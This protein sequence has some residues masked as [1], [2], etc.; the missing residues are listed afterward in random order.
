[1]D[2]ACRNDVLV[3]QGVNAKGYGTIALS[4]MTDRR[5]SVESKAIYAYL[6]AYTGR[7]ATCYPSVSTICQDLG[8]S[9][10]RYYKFFAPLKDLGY[11]STAQGVREGSAY[12]HNVYTINQV[13]S[14]PRSPGF[15]PA[16]ESPESSAAAEP[17][18]N[19][20]GRFDH[21]R[22]EGGGPDCGKLG[23]VEKSAAKPQVN[24]AG[25]F[26]HVQIDHTNNK[27]Y[28]FKELKDLKTHKGLEDLDLPGED[29][30]VAPGPIA[31][32]APEAPPPAPVPPSGGACP[33]T[34]GGD[35][36]AQETDR[37]LTEAEYLDLAELCASAVNDNGN[38]YAR[39]PYAS[40]VDDGYA[41]GEIAAAWRSR[42]NDCSARACAP[43]FY[44]N[45]AEFLRST[46]S[47]GARRTIDAARSRAAKKARS[48]AALRAEK[49]AVRATERREEDLRSE[50][51]QYARAA[52]LVEE[53]KREFVEAMSA[54][55]RRSPVEPAGEQAQASLVGEAKA[56]LEA[57]LKEKAKLAEAARR[58]E[59]GL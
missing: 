6:C 45:L 25:R 17:Q 21:A 57:A 24:G 2:R 13:V 34:E 5:L 18:V 16:P 8:V 53:R 59:A 41:A 7:G 3:V 4:A 26:G 12:R 44:P 33:E 29:S 9:Q 52:A 39:R 50:S 28:G 15:G 23:N 11:V 51:P 48:E 43:E 22:F 10:K 36:P 32:I 49:E 37:A 40:L 47:R 42:Q 56:R 38:G 58:S 31:R 1:M 14:A 46:A 35:L 54:E 20:A 19:G 27:P 30:Q 55:R